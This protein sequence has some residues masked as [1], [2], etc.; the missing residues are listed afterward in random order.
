[1]SQYKKSFSTVQLAYLFTCLSLIARITEQ[2]ILKTKGI[3]H[4][5]YIKEKNKILKSLKQWFNPPHKVGKKNKVQTK[6]KQS[7]KMHTS[8]YH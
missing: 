6:V 2:Q 1:M 4:A 5:I 3:I 8:Y 7:V